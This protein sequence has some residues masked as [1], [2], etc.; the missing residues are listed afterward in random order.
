MPQA[1]DH[2]VHFVPR[3]LATLAR[4]RALRHFDLQFVCVDQIVRGH[5]E[6]SRGYLLYRAAPQN[7]AGLPPEALFV[8]P[9]LARVRLATNA[10]HGD[11]QRLMRFFTD[12]A[13]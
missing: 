9:P 3:K 1:S 4:L 10:V 13:K 8:L 6:T 2:F 5:T 11:G 12:G 7:P